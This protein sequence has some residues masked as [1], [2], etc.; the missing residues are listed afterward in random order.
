MMKCNAKDICLA[1][2]S[3]DLAAQKR[4]IRSDGTAERIK[5]WEKRLEQDVRVQ[6]VAGWQ[7]GR[8]RWGEFEM[9]WDRSVGECELKSCEPRIS[10]Q[11]ESFTLR[12][13]SLD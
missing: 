7:S 2:H 6:D 5:R 8:C 1:R 10:L 12:R 3:R 13:K 4:L 9:E 11:C